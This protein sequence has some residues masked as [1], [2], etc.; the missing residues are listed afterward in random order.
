MKPP[1]F[2]GSKFIKRESPYGFG[3]TLEILENGSIGASFAFDEHK[4]GAPGVAHGGAISAVLDEAM[5]AA[6]Y[7]TGRAGVTITMTFNFKAPVP[8]DMLVKVRAWVERIEGKKTFTA[9][10]LTLADGSLAVEGSGIFYYSEKLAAD[11]A[12]RFS[13]EAA[14]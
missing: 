6:A 1:N 13:Q 7:I 5:G 14:E 4:Q 9:C 3:V 2:P 12:Q 11:L 10:S 8:L